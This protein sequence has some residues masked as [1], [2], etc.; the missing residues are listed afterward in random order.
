MYKLAIVDDEMYSLNTVSRILDWRE[1]GFEIMGLF[2]DVRELLDFL[3]HNTLDAVLTD[4]KMPYMSGLE[5]AEYC[6]TFHPRIKFLFFS[7]YREFEYA[8]KAIEYNIVSYITKPV[9]KTAL[10][11]AAAKLYGVLKDSG[12]TYFA[13]IS[14]EFEALGE[15]LKETWLYGK[16]RFAAAIKNLIH[17][18][19]S[20]FVTTLTDISDSDVRLTAIGQAK[21]GADFEAL[22]NA[23]C[24]ETVVNIENILK[25]RLRFKIVR[26]TNNITDLSCYNNTKDSD[27][28]AMNNKDAIM[29]SALKYIADNFACDITLYD[30]AKTLGFSPNYFSV[31]FKRKTGENFIDCLIALRI[32]K[33]K[34]LLMETDLKISAVSESV[35]YANHSHFYK[36]FKAQVGTTPNNYRVK[37]KDIPM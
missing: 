29:N 27:C 32:E 10:Q 28:L 15:Y 19:D 36:I 3:E 12:S 23:F 26:V 37:S 31:Y 25:T 11:A 4:I 30:T 7:A 6:C 1:E 2:Y 9:S 5:L 34:E 17:S 8:K 20:S 24:E 35:G 16:D 22:I 14:L 21:S 18:S 13:D 33:A